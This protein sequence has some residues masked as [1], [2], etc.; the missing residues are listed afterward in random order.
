[1]RV[2]T[3]PEPSLVLLIGP[4]GS[5][6]STFAAKHFLATEVVSSDRCRAM[7]VDDEADQ[8]ISRDAFSLLHFIAR[9]RLLRQKLTVID[10]T[11]LNEAARS[12]LLDLARGA[13]V[14]S[15]AIVFSLRLATLLANNKARQ[16]RVVPEDV[17][18][19]QSLRLEKTMPRLERE[20]YA[21]IYYLD[22]AAL[23]EATV[24]RARG[25]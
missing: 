22:E 9:L 11:N 2:L 6:K 12:P 5:G 1:M 4:S 17:I 14:P 25:L 23:S 10:A 24:S 16:V 21:A 8:S 15:V 7:L 13:S 3:I 18:A 20:G 19:T